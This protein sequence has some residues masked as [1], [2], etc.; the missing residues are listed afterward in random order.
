MNKNTSSFELLNF[1]SKLTK[2][3][4]VDVMD[5]MFDVCVWG[6]GGGLGR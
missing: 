2:V 4:Y 3:W 6:G 1:P 5:G